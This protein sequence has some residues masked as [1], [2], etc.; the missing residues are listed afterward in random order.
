LQKEGYSKHTIWNDLKRLRRL[1]EQCEIQD[2][3]ALL[4]W[5]LLFLT[6]DHVERFGVQG[7]R[8]RG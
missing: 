3:E 1:D 4:E 7:V 8:K 6:P 2:P 5:R